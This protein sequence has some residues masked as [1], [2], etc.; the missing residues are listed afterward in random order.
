[1][2]DACL[3]ERLDDLIDPDSLRVSGVPTG[4][5][6]GEPGCNK[7]WTGPGGGPW[8]PP[9]GVIQGGPW[10]TPKDLLWHP[11]KGGWQPFQGTTQAAGASWDCDVWTREGEGEAFQHDWGYC[12]GCWSAANLG[13]WKRVGLGWSRFRSHDA[14]WQ[15]LL[16]KTSGC[17]HFPSWV[18][19]ER[20]VLQEWH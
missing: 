1:M 15:L 9:W 3:R 19:T 14:A 17:Q 12:W 8:A 5:R 13:G 7:H 16:A 6:K 11:T 20:N 2:G 4:V 10:G 18:G